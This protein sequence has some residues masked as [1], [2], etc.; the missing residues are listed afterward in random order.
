MTRPGPRPTPTPL[1]LLRGERRSSRVNYN[2]PVAPE[3]TPELR[4]D[5]TDPDVVATW[6]ELVEM[7]GSLGVLSPVDGIA[8][9]SFAQAVVINRRSFA[10]VSQSAVLIKDRDGSLRKNPALMPWRDSFHAILR[11]CQEFGLT[12]SA[13]TLL[14][15][16]PAATDARERLLS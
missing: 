7:V 9:L 10:L 11:M 4:P 5:V 1:K 3:G 8:L 16:P 2:A 14:V 15:N 12:P 13:R 6:H